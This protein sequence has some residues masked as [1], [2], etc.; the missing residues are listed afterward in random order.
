MLI[1]AKQ[2][3]NSRFCGFGGANSLLGPNETDIYLSAKLELSEAS[4][5]GQL[6]EMS[7]S[8]SNNN[9]EIARQYMS[10][11]V[12]NEFKYDYLVRK[13]WSDINQITTQSN[14]IIS[15]CNFRSLEK[16][17]KLLIEGILKRFNQY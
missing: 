16:T 12:Q 11:L 7:S 1:G 15:N 14:Y 6:N 8:S 3:F 2:L 13:Q 9:N 5:C 10:V 17:L 4:V